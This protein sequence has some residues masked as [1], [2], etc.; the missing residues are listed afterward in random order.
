MLNENRF[1][2]TF[3]FEVTTHG[4]Q[5]GKFELRPLKKE[6]RINDLSRP[7]SWWEKLSYVPIRPGL[8]KLQPK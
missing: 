7:Q 2:G 1:L 5:L 8:N 6:G 3:N 4:L